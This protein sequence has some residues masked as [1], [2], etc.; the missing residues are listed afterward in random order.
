MSVVEETSQ[1]SEE[2][3]SAVGEA[4]ESV[5]MIGAAVSEVAEL[6]AGIALN[7]GRISSESCTVREGIVEIAG[8]A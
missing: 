6:V 4:R 2:S 8:L 3:A 7:V 5:G 1:R